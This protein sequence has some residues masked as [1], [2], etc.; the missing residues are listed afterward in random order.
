MSVINSVNE[1]LLMYMGTAYHG[2]GLWTWYFSQSGQLYYTNCPYEKELKSFFYLGGC[3]DYAIKQQNEPATPFLMSDSVGLVWLGEYVREPDQQ[4]RFIVVGPAFHAYSSVHSIEDSLRKLNLSIPVRNSYVKLLLDM[5]VVSLQ[6]FQS[7]ARVMHHSIGFED[8]QNLELRYQPTQQLTKSTA[9]GSLDE[10]YERGNFRQQMLLQFVREGNRNHEE[11]IKSLQSRGSDMYLEGNPLRNTK[12]T[13]IIFTSQCAGAAIEGGLPA[14]IAKETE[15]AY[16]RKIEQNATPT[17]LINIT[18]EMLDAFIDLVAEYK[19]NSSISRPIR[20]CCAY[21]KKHIAEPLSL[22]ELAA[23]IGYT[24]YY[25]S[26]KFQKEM[27]VKLL[28]YIKQVRLDYAKILLSTTSLT[29]QEVSE[30]LQFGTRNYFTR[31]FKEYSGTSPV[32]YRQLVW[33]DRKEVK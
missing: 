2:Y 32:E 28:D 13:F 29:V 5:P 27:G 17:D 19:E 1:R 30:R 10:D 16:I 26:R 31:I 7:L 15:R 20:L 9:E 18:N 8:T 25:L 14:K 3:M 6:N 23:E 4:Q 33:G 21:I 24:E 22:K 12:N 11:F